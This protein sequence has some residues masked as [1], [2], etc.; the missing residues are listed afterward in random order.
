MLGRFV[1]TDG[2]V[3]YVANAAFDA[4]VDAVMARG[5][6]GFVVIGRDAERGAQLFVE[7]AEIAELRDANWNLGAVMRKE[8]LLVTGIPQ[9]RELALRHDRRD[10]GHLEAT[11]VQ[12]AQFGAAIVFLNANDSA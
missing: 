5:A 6:E 9:V 12:L 4:I 3:G 2:F 10:H 8:K 1:R 11:L 7:A